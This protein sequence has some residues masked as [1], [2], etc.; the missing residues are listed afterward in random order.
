[1]ETKMKSEQAARPRLQH[2]G[3]ATTDVDRM[4]EWYAKVLGMEVIY[5]T[6]PP[7]AAPDRPPFSAAFLTND[8]VHHRIAL[9]ET[10]GVVPDP[11]KRSHARVQHMAFEYETLGQLLDAYARLKDLGVTP[12][13]AADEGVQTVLYYED[14]EQNVVELNVNN[15]P[16]NHAATEHMR[17]A[18]ADRPRRA[19]IDPEQLLAALRRGVS[20]WALHERAFAGEFAP[21]APFDPRRLA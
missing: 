5:R 11:E 18:P 12:V 8:E 16:D 13:L 6:A 2:V 15:Y 14:P 17:N 20:P 7:T 10:P 4:I 3:I 1:M 21:T 9:L 19:L